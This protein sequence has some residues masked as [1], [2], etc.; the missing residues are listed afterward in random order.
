MLKERL[1][2][3][4]LSF[5]SFF[6]VSG[7]QQHLQKTKTCSFAKHQLAGYLFSCMYLLWTGSRTMKEG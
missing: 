1:H 4:L 6:I 3:V 5:V 7:S 2:A